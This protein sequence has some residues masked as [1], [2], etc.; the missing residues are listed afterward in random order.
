MSIDQQRRCVSYGC[1]LLH[2]VSE[3]DS[4]FRIRLS[5]FIYATFLPFS[6]FAIL[7]TRRRE[8]EKNEFKLKISKKKLILILKK[9][10]KIF[11]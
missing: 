10:R 1:Y 5:I 3:N 7:K 4:V 11:F 8:M 6:R 9:I 2:Y